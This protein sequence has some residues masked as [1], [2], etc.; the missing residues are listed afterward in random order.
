MFRSVVSRPARTSTARGTP[1]R[2]RRRRRR[3]WCRRDD[4]KWRISLV[5][6]SRGPSP[7][8]LKKS[9]LWGRHLTDRC[10]LI[11]PSSRRCGS[12]LSFDF[13]V[14]S[15][16]S[17]RPLILFCVVVVHSSATLP[18]RRRRRLLQSLPAFFR[19]TPLGRFYRQKGRAPK[20]PLETPNKSPRRLP[21]AWTR[22]S[23]VEVIVV[24]LS[25][26][27]GAE[28]GAQNGFGVSYV[29]SPTFKENCGKFCLRV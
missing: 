15:R 6:P 2:R 10:R 1:G 26:A 17:T 20:A 24:S 13:D 8:R 12:F 28:E 5:L 11:R 16:F 18:P 29:F 27:Q 23:R 22:A 25:L 4:E 19:K 3:R 21:A 7:V 14:F 9:F